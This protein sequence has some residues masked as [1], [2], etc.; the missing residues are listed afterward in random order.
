MSIYHK[1]D[2]SVCE[3]WFLKEAIS[4]IQSDLD[5]SYVK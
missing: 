3:P 2:S 1:Y 4:W 5:G